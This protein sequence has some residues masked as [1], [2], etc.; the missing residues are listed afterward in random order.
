M[1]RVA[2]LLGCAL[3][4][5]SAL[6]DV[7]CSPFGGGAFE[8]T[9]DTQCG[10]GTCSSGFCSFPDPACESGLRYGE[11]SGPSSNQCVGGTTPDGGSEDMVIPDSGICY[12]TGLVRACFAAAPAGMKVLGGNI[13]T[14]TEAMCDADPRNA[15]WCVIAGASVAVPTNVN[16][17]GSKPLVLV[18]AETIDVVATLDVSSKRATGQL[19]AGANAN[20]CAAGTAPGASGGGAG[21]SFGGKGGNGGGGQ[22]NATGG[23]PGTPVTPTTLHGGCRGQD[24]NGGSKG[25]GG[26]GGGALYLIAETSITV[27]GIV[28]ASGAGGGG[29]TANQSGGGGGGAGGFIGL[30]A[31]TVTN[32]GNIVSHGGGGGEGSGTTADGAPGADVTALSPAAG[33]SGGAFTGADGGDGAIDASTAGETG[34]SGSGGGGAGGG[35]VGIIRVDRA[36][37]ITGSGNVSPAAT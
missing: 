19:G 12:G 25:A 14:D 27:S 8:C 34:G 6:L 22:N 9:L 32:I 16:V 36:S 26:N 20:A 18:A 15:A 24:G 4:A 11:A 1:A 10:A 35:G 31:P 29:G 21:G 33:G 7:G 28:N 5:S 17:T 23:V 30:D 13:N 37:A 3:F 2:G